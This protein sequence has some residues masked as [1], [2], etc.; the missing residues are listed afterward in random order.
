VNPT[1]GRNLSLTFGSLDVACEANAV[2]LDNEAA[3]NDLVTFSDV[4]TR[5]DRRWFFTLTGLADYGSGS[6]W[7]LLWDAPPFAALAY[8][9][10]P[11]GNATPTPARP[12][13]TGFVYVSTT[14]PVGGD[15]GRTWWF[16]TR[17]ACTDL[18]TRKVA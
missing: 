12:H 10:K 5:R 13:F 7:T 1:N 4:T 15:A 17:L 11:Y 3:D 16:E 14:P 9:F 6:F 2:V 18:P 8:V